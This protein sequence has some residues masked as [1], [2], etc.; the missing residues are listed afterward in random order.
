[1]YFDFEFGQRLSRGKI[2]FALATALSCALVTVTGIEYFRSQTSFD[3]V[4]TELAT[5]R[6]KNANDIKPVVAKQD[7]EQLQT[8]F[9]LAQQTVDQLGIPWAKVFAQVSADATNDVSLLSLEPN[10]KEK[11]LTLVAEARNNEAMFA[12]V[13]KFQRNDFFR[14]VYLTHHSANTQDP[15]RP[16]QFTLLARWG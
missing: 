10:A 7:Q 12:Y 2:L 3:D 4:Q 6:N 8:E 5:A 14:E 13:L 11:E 15:L 1:M 16:V 9:K